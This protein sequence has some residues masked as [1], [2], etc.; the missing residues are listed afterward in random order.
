MNTVETRPQ[1]RETITSFKSADVDCQLEI[2]W[3]AYD[4]LG[5]ALASVVPVALLSQAVQQLIRQ[6]GQVSREEKL[7]I[8]RDIL[9]GADTRFTHAYAALNANMK[10]AFWHRLFSGRDWPGLSA[11]VACHS[12]SSQT[13]AL[14]DRLNTMGLNER[15]NFLRQVLA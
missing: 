13:Q 8:L 14:L 9:A 3:Q 4:T 15:L 6:L 11:M 2:L 10:L 7:A 12:P 1:F 5:Q